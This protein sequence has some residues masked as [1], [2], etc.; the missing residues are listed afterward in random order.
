M[1]QVETIV[2]RT[3]M[4][5]L[6]L[7]GIAYEIFVRHGD[8]RIVLLITDLVLIGLVPVEL[9]ISRADRRLSADP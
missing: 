4:F 3:L 7:G 2:R 9:L 1:T 8:A 6:G 5:G